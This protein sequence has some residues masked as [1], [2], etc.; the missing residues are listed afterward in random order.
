M[1]AGLVQ[2]VPRYARTVS[3]PTNGMDFG[4]P[5]GNALR[6]D[7]G[8]SMH[9]G[10]RDPLWCPC[11]TDDGCDLV[12]RRRNTE[13]WGGTHR[14]KGLRGSAHEGRQCEQT[15]HFPRP[16]DLGRILTKRGR[17]QE[18]TRRARLTIHSERADLIKPESRAGW[19]TQHI[20]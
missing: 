4:W 15:E 18:A 14:I 10:R 7:G 1:A 8:C 6:P 2:L 11:A 5:C 20:E 9:G 12:R 19:V 16:Q 3:L 13:C 17:G